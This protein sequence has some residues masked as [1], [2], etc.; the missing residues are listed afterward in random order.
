VSDQFMATHYTTL[1]CT[2]ASQRAM[3]TM[4]YDRIEPLTPMR[5]PTVVNNGLSSMK[6]MNHQAQVTLVHNVKKVKGLKT[7]TFSNKGKTRVRIQYGD[8]DSCHRSSISKPVPV[9]DTH[10]KRTHVRSTDGCS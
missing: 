5:E 4:I 10:E 3:R 1:T 7:Q 8:D 2:P 9:N 6:P